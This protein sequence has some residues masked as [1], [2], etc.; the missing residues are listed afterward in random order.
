M[1]LIMIMHF[2]LDPVTNPG[3]G[4]LFTA[5]ELGDALENHY[6]VEVRYLPRPLW[7]SIDYL[8]DVDVLVTLLDAFDLPRAL[9]ASKNTD[10]AQ[11]DSTSSSTSSS[12]SSSNNGGRYKV[13]AIAGYTTTRVKPTLITIAWMRNWFHRWISWPWIGNYDLLLTSSSLSKAFVDR[14]SRGI[15]F[16]VQCFEGCPTFNIPELTESATGKTVVL[17]KKGSPPKK[18]QLL[19][20]RARVQVEV[21]RLATSMGGVTVPVQSLRQQQPPPVFTAPAYGTFTLAE[22]NR[23]AV[24]TTTTTAT[25]TAANIDSAPATTIHYVFTGSY[26]NSYRSIMAFDPA[27]LLPKWKGLV[28][29]KG[30]DQKEAAVSRSWKDTCTGLLP[31]TMMPYVSSVA[32]WYSY[33]YA[34]YNEFYFPPSLSILLFMICYESFMGI[35]SWLQ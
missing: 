25:A 19:H 24:T 6:S 11:A 16:N 23:P 35:A 14:I 21:M 3:A 4:D 28:V 29:G 8:Y 33:I 10:F 22:R 18:D 9:S 31:Y 27:L 34:R 15:G 30:W 12:S 17:S 26:Y 1:I 5:R 7:Y 20:K 13:N 32:I 2:C